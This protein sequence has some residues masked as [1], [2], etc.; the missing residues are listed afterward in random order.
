MRIAK[1]QESLARK[2]LYQPNTR[3]DDLF[4]LVAHPYWLWVATESVL[5]SESAKLAGIDGVTGDD[6]KGDLHDYARALSIDLRAGT[7]KPQPVKRVSLLK[8]DDTYRSLGISSLRDRVVQEATRMVLEPIL[9]S[10]FLNC[11][12]GFRPGR[13]VMDAIHLIGY[14]TRNKAKMWWLAEGTIKECFGSIPH[15]RLRGVLEQYI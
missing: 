10:H 11:S 2:A 15:D 9:E 7:Y 1:V 13:R 3:F 14:F 5:Q 8:A 6:I 4:S 12:T